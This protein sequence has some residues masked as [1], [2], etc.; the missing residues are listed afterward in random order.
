MEVVRE[1]EDM[2]L[3]EVIAAQSLDSHAEGGKESLLS[4]HEM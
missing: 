4:Q 1:R 3:R 2:R